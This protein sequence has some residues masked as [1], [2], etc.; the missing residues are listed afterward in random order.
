MNN[1][2]DPKTT[3]FRSTV[4]TIYFY[5]T[6][7]NGKRTG[8]MCQP[9][10]LASH[11]GLTHVKVA[12][13]CVNRSA[14]LLASSCMEHGT[15]DCR[16]L[17]SVLLFVIT[18]ITVSSLLVIATGT[19]DNIRLGYSF[20]IISPVGLCCNRL[21]LWPVHPLPPISVIPDCGHSCPCC[22][23][24]SLRVLG[25]IQASKRELTSYCLHC[26]CYVR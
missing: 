6:A 2:V 13:V 20:W 25:R 26:Y 9:E 8:L 14:C 16:Q 10:N 18:S 17:F 19:R 5:C 7:L 24:W 11:P 12:S 3:A 23:D 4:I 21:V 1:H 22:T 15:N